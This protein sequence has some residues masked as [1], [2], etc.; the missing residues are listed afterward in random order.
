VKQRKKLI[1]YLESLYQ[2]NS[3]QNITMFISNI[4]M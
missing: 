1:A 2:I 3:I 4:T